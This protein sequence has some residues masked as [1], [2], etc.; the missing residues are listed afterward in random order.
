MGGRIYQLEGILAPK[1]H[2]WKPQS[3]PKNGSTSP[4]NFPEPL[5]KKG[6]MSFVEGTLWAAAGKRPGR[7]KA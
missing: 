6:T 5:K 3:K 1:G 2:D 7:P 4:S